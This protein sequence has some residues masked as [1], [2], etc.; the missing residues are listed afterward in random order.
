MK[1][2]V[3]TYQMSAN[4][5]GLKDSHG[6]KTRNTGKSQTIWSSVLKR[7]VKSRQIKFVYKV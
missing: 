5:M 1:M 4:V 6:I 2:N 3:Y 7:I